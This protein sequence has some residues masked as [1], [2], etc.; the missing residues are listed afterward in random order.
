MCVFVERLR[1]LGDLPIG[2]SRK[3]TRLLG[4]W[5]TPQKGEIDNLAKRAL[6]EVAILQV[7]RAGLLRR[8]EAA[9]LRWG[10]VEL[11]EDGSGWLHVVRSKT[12][13]ARGRVALPGHGGRGCLPSHQGGGSGVCVSRCH[14]GPRARVYS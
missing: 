11:H 9:A 6:V 3:N 5:N 1:K 4:R 14:F 8:S 2:T 13:Q 12:D 7:I 10:D